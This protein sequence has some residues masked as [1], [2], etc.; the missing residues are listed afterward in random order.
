MI[1]RQAIVVQ[2]EKSITVYVPYSRA[3]HVGMAT[4]TFDGKTWSA[5]PDAG[6]PLHM[7]ASK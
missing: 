3:D 5:T 1:T 4:F 7:E 2:S 6:G